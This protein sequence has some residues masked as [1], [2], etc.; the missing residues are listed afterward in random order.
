MIGVLAGVILGLA[1]QDPATT[2]SQAS[3]AT[4][5]SGEMVPVRPG[6]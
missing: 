5:L 3:Q 2:L 6:T 4:R 1:P